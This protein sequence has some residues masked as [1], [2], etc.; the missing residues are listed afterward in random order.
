[1][2][3]LVHYEALLT[4]ILLYDDQ[5]VFLESSPALVQQLQNIIC[6]CNRPAVRTD[7]DI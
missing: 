1:M 7:A 5:S 3:Y 2:M 4:D 6:I